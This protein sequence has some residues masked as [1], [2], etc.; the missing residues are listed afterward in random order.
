M[1]ARHNPF[2]SERVRPGALPYLFAEDAGMVKFVARLRAA[3]MRGQIVGP[4]G[5]GKSTLLHAAA[6]RLREEGLRV[7]EL[8]AP[9]PWLLR[10]VRGADAALVDELDSLPAS[11]RVLS[12]ALLRRRCRGLLAATHDSLGL[13]TLCTLAPDQRTL[14]AVVAALGEEV[15][16]EDLRQAF[17]ASAGNL[18]LALFWLYDRWEERACASREPW[19]TA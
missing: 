2:C 5:S 19:R 12:L 10:G 7:V 17:E 8:R 11:L 15:P 1:G 4:H 16:A 13:P 3:N 9:A 14:Q 18:R 6:R